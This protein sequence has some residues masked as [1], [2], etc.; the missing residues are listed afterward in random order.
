MKIVISTTNEAKV[1]GVKKAFEDVFENCEFIS[2]K[3]NSDVSDQPLSEKEGIN[4]AI[5]RAKNSMSKFKD[6]DFYVGLEG[7]VDTKDWGMFLAGA[8]AVIG[9]N[10]DIG[11]GISYQ[12]QLP[13]FME[14][15]INSGKELGPIV[16]ELM[17]DESNNI[18]H[19]EG[20]MSILTNGRIKRIFEF[21][22]A[23]TCALARF[24]TPD[25]YSK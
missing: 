25:L 16:Q 12:L 13:L 14:K 7:Y 21:E 1:N 24:I 2:E 19:T 3:F 8:S 5:N 18:R 17:K 22:T 10:G 15:Q 9:S 4:G 11:I 6:A 23:T 20:T